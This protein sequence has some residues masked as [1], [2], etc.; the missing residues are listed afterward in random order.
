VAEKKRVDALFAR[1]EGGLCVA[2]R[3]SFEDRAIVLRAEAA[4]EAL[5]VF[6]TLADDDGNDYGKDYDENK[7]TRDESWIGWI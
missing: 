1:S 3:A 2:F 6:A 7:D 4:A 5:G